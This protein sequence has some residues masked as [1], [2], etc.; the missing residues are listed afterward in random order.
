M[1]FGLA[2]KQKKN[3]NFFLNSLFIF[4]S[5]YFWP[6]DASTVLFVHGYICVVIYLSSL[7]MVA[8]SSWSL[9]GDWLYFLFNAGYSGVTEERG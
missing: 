1:E 5:N 3:L 9:K 6:F 8:I 2:T 4:S 7:P